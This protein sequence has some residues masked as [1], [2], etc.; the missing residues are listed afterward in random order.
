MTHTR[1]WLSSG[2]RLVTNHLATFVLLALAYVVV[3]GAASRLYI[4]QLII[5]GPATA[6]IFAVI[7]HRLNTGQLDL[8]RLQGGLQVFVRAMLVWVVSAVI[9]G[10]GL[11]LLIIPGIVIIRALE[12][13]PLD[14]VYHLGW[15][16][17]LLVLCMPIA[18]IVLGVLELALCLFPLILVVDRGMPLW[19]AMEESRKKVQRNPGFALALIGINLLGQMCLWVGLLV[20]I[21]VSWCAVASA[22]RELWSEPRHAGSC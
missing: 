22:Y 13:F 4:L 1:V 16:E 10:I 17:L 9:A 15:E 12:P 21:P 3:M 2:W 11:F 14:R 8:N 19:A 7:L 5:G 20:T 6:A 18:A